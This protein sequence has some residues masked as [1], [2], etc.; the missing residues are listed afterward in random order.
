[1]KTAWEVNDG[2]V[3]VWAIQ[4]GSDLAGRAVAKAGSGWGRD[5]L[6]AWTVSIEVRKGPL[7]VGGPWGNSR[8]G[9]VSDPATL[10]N[11]MLLPVGPCRWRTW[12]DRLAHDGYQVFRIL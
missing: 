11:D 5:G 6:P 3:Q 4:L 7:A 8:R 9:R 10:L 2:Q 12:V 1:M